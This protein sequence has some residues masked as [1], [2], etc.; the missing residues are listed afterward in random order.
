LPS[1]YDRWRVGKVNKRQPPSG[2][3]PTDTLNEN[4]MEYLLAD[5]QDTLITRTS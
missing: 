2:K 4:Q 5:S 3:R 1:T